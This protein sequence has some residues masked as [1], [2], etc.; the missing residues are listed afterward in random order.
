[1]NPKC[2][3]SDKDEVTLAPVSAGVPQT[4]TIWII[5]YAVY[6]YITLKLVPGPLALLE[7][8]PM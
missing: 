7:W 4:K 5:L 2:S 6:A 8:A 3:V 1:M